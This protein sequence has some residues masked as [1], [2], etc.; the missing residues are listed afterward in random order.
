MGPGATVSC[1]LA[2]DEINGRLHPSRFT[3]KTMPTR[4][5]KLKDPLAPVFRKRID[6]ASALKQVEKMLAA[7]AR[8]SLD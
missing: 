3:I 4:F 2:W 6:L 1:P 5:E 7:R 8:A